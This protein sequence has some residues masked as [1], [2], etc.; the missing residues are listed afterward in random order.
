VTLSR[1]C[2]AA[3]WLGRCRQFAVPW[4]T[5]LL[6][7]LALLT[8]AVSDASYVTTTGDGSNS[9]GSGA[10]TGTHAPAAGV[11]SFTA[12]EQTAA[13]CLVS[14]GALSGGT[15][16]A[17]RLE[18][19]DLSTGAVYQTTATSNVG[20]GS[21]SHTPSH[22]VT[23]YKLSSRSGTNWISSGADAKSATCVLTAAMGVALSRAGGCAIR[24]TGTLWCW[25]YNG[26]GE[27]G[28]GDDITRT[29]PAQVGA[30][31][32]WQQIDGG[33]QH[34]C[35]TRTDGTLWCWGSNASGQLG[36]ASS[37]DRTNPVQVSAG[38]TTWKQVSSGTSHSCAVRTTG[39]LWC[40]G[41]NASSQLGT[42]GGSVTSATQ[43]GVAT[44]WRS[45]SAG[46]AHTCAVRTDGT[47]WC[48]GLNAS[49][50]LGM[51]DTTTRTTPTQIGA[52]TTWSMVATGDD[53][54]C[55][56]RTD[57]TMWCWGANSFGEL[58]IGSTSASPSPAQVASGTSW[59]FVSA[60]ANG[61][62]AT[63]TAA[64]AW[65][66]G[67]NSRGTVGDATTTDRNSPV[68]LSGA[69]VLQIAVGASLA[70]SIRSDAIL[71][72][73]G[74]DG[75]GQ[76]GQG[77]SSFDAPLAVDASQWTTVS[78]GAEHTCG[79]KT[80][81]TLWCWGSNTYGQIGATTA[82]GWTSTPV[83]V[84]GSNWTAVSAGAYHT[85][86]I[87]SPGT[88]W[89]WGANESG[90]LGD[91]STTTRTSPT[92]VGGANDWLTVSAGGQFTC[93]LR[94]V[95]LFNDTAWCWGNGSSGQLGLGNTSSRTTPGQVSTGLDNPID[96]SAG[97]ATAC[98]IGTLLLASNGY[99]WGANTYGQVGDGTT[100]QR[101]SPTYISNSVGQIEPGTDF[102]CGMDTGSGL[103]CWGHNDQHQLGDG[104]TTDQHSPLQIGSSY[105]AVMTMS[106]GGC[107]RTTGGALKCWGRNTSGQIG[108]GTI[109]ASV[110]TP[111]Q[112]LTGV[113]S[114][115]VGTGTNSE[116]ACAIIGGTLDVRCWGR[117]LDGE[118]GRSLSSAS[119]V[120]V[121]GGAV[122]RT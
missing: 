86:G 22:P 30:A 66:W 122:W 8:A 38:V 111:T 88:L 28:L 117:Q 116:S 103:W 102:T 27:L 84:A 49:G 21:F 106:A 105:S 113:Q 31:T 64:N 80:G 70:C 121:S 77:T 115:G 68:Q 52:L 92:Q 79:I 112:I 37:T 1:S 100:T 55:A 101:T 14:W 4:G 11:A 45:V 98:F 29:T 65:C 53:H 118:L 19:S 36:D 69:S 42:G 99:C 74:S 44:T 58:G 48:W 109:S 16:V 12:V 46:R 120:S 7:A 114:T 6:V 78:S 85:C 13:S 35:G 95:F 73:W 67:E 87:Q 2:G 32:T 41:S 33:E 76:L 25:G 47:L 34:M 119:P 3:S 56:T 93:G 39:T 90:E 72:C 24:S 63:D 81:S 50:Q 82:N 23:T 57:S 59:S 15:A 94:S 62:C 40:W 10:L 97:A 43:V 107:A 71:R 61:A 108:N 17:D 60:G 91:G 54:T 75:S 9:L 89:C 110:S 18:I 26:T 96:I 5:A 20:A 51:G 83:Q 104:T